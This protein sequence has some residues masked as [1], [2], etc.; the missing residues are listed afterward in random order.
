MKEQLTEEQIEKLFK[1]VKSKYVHFIDVQY[2]IV[3]HLASAIEEKQEENPTMSFDRAL[4]EEYSKFPITGFATMTAEKHT[5]LTRFWYKK[6]FQY[7][8]GYFKLPK[9]II[10]AAI[11][12]LIS[13][14]LIHGNTRHL[15]IM[16]FTLILLALTGIVYRSKKGFEFKK[17]LREKYLV[18]NTYISLFSGLWVLY[19]YCPIYWSIESLTIVEPLS[20]STLQVWLLSIYITIVSILMYAFVFVF[21]EMLKQELAE[22]YAHLNIKLT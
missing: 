12:F 3:D 15:V 18:T 7:I 20:Y 19:F 4:R 14:G 13:Q 9:I 2:E 8:L 5:A 1:F 17:G 16:Y 10:S 11:A 22:K 6:V 21:P